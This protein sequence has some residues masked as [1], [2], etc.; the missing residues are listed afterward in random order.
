MKNNQ[1]LNWHLF[2]R[3]LD[4]LV[5]RKLWGCVERKT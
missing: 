4:L 1:N 3:C 5:R 2:R